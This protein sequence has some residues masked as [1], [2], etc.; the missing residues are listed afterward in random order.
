MILITGFLF[1]QKIDTC[2]GY[3]MSIGVGF[4]VA[5]VRQCLFVYVW[6]IF[7]CILLVYIEQI[8]QSK[9]NSLK[10]KFS[11][12]IKQK[13]KQTKKAYMIILFRILTSY[14]I[15]NCALGLFKAMSRSQLTKG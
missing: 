11:K 9:E 5:F 10:Q 6:R 12:D 3:D 8:W 2:I 1:P 15:Y 7:M 4:V 14:I 13:R